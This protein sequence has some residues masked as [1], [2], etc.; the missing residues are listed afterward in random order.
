[1][2]CN[3]GL[4]MFSNNNYL[5]DVGQFSNNNTYAARCQQPTGNQGVQFTF[6]V[7][8]QASSYSFSLGSTHQP[9]GIYSNPINTQNIVPGVGTP[10]QHS[11]P[12]PMPW[13]EDSIPQGNS[14]VSAFSAYPPVSSTFSIYR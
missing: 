9:R 7:P 6:A 4:G 11:I 8:T 10:W 5:P 13:S 1:M 14:G 2:S 12:N 3:L